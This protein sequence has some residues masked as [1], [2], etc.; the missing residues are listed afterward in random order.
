[1]RIAITSNTLEPGGAERQRVLLA[2][3]L[4][5]RG[6][7]VALVL[8]QR[9]GELEGEARP[10]VRVVRVWRG[11]EIPPSDAII[12]GTTNTESLV[13][14]RLRLGRNH[15][16]WCAAVHNPVG[17]GCPQLKRFTRAALRAA[18]AVVALSTWHRE[19]VRLRLGVKCTDTIGN[20][21]EA[22]RFR[23]V[24]ASRRFRPPSYE[25][26]FI[27]RL[28]ARHKGL[29][30]LLEA[31]TLQRRT[32]VIAG[33]GPDKELLRTQARR[34]GL[35]DRLAWLGVQA[36]E[37]FFREID[38]LMV[39]SRYEGSPMVVLEALAAGVP[40]IATD[41]PGASDVLPPECVVTDASPAGLSGAV[42][43]F[44]ASPYRPG[45]ERTVVRTSDEMTLDYESLC[46]RLVRTRR[47]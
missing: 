44:F 17:P 24:A 10:E 47:S 30:R 18:D 9:G 39:P 11:E 29:D 45:A 34:L 42:D 20:G 13:A 14:L 32:L 8:L 3:G 36:P 41:F 15:V 27:G 43:A 35:T 26:G 37:A 38:V 1:M 22:E 46:E 23:P 2:N 7:K 31:W 16:L 6:H 19:Q 25:V 12:T 5:R 21:I 33:D 28:E 4:A 40:V